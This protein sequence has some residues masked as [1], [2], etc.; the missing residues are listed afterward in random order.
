MKVTKE[1]WN[2]IY[3]SADALGWD[4]DRMSTSGQ[5]YYNDLMNILEKINER[6]EK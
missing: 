1:E 4:I 5:E 3:H 6:G 2:E